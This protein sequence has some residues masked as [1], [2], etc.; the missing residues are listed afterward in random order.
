MAPPVLYD[1]GDFLDD[2]AVH[3]ALR[4]DLGI[5]CLV[6]IDRSGPRRVE[7]VPL[8]LDHARTELARG[9]DARWIA[10]RLTSSCAAFG[11]RVTNE[12]ERLVVE[13]EG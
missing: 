5:L 1:L 13:V 7:A 4:N 11:T 10:R 8:H 2:Y 12:G 6:T 9:E 3:P